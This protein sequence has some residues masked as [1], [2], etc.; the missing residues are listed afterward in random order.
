MIRMKYLFMTLV[1]AIL[2]TGC[3]KD[4][5]ALGTLSEVS[6]SETF[7]SIPAEGGQVQVVVKAS[8]AWQM[9]DLRQGAEGTEYKSGVKDGEPT[10]AALWCNVSQLS[11]EAGETTL[12]ISAPAST[13]G[14]Q[15]EI[16]IEAGGKRQHLLVRQG[17]FDAETVTCDFLNKQGVDG[18]NYRVKGVVTAIASTTYGN[19]YINDGTG[20]VYIYG[21]LDKDGAEKNFSSLGIELGDEITVEGP[22]TTYGTTIEMVNVT[23]IKITKSLLKIVEP[24]NAPELPKEGGEFSVKVAYKGSGAYVTIPDECAGFVS[25]KNSQ[26]IAGV[27]TKLEKNPADTCVFTFQVHPN[28]GSA[29]TG[30]VLFTSSTGSNKTELS[31][32]F[33]QLGGIA[34]VNCATF[35]AAEDGP[36]Q[37]RVQGVVTA[38]ANTKYGNLTLSDAS[39]SMT[40][41][42]TTNFA[43]HDINVGDI[44]TY[45]GVHSSHKGAP[46]MKD[47]TI[48]A[49][50]D[51]EQVTVQQFRDAAV[52]ADKWYMISGTVEQATEDNTKNDIETY[53]NLNIN[54][55]TASVYVYGVTTGWNGEKK[56]FGSLGVGYGD[57]L[58]IIAHRA[59]Y[60]GLTQAASAF[61]VSHK[62]AE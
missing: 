20:E 3:S 2:F 44:V 14:H 39:G 35:N 55:G 60:K 34:D 43:D 7:L 24:A 37:Y 1:A 21:T 8:T 54:D 33:S 40:V 50:I 30:S 29:R 28:E 58:T 49:V 52:D 4:D 23:V 53:G 9:L 27:P 10:Y 38:I 32:S 59:D 51:V 19:L 12:T 41:Y 56:Q 45:V 57:E 17:T 25:Y 46:Q 48:E 36:A 18:K 47:G 26:F 5:D 13:S 42:G 62:K 22:R 6:L 61:Y 31:F 15:T 11:G 16:I